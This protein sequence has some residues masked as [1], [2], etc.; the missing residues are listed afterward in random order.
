M[1]KADT[2]GATG[3]YLTS[4]GKQGDAAWG[5]RGRWCLLTGQTE[6]HE[7]DDCDPRPSE[8][9]RISDLLA[10]ARI[11][12]V[13]GESAGAHIFDPKAPPFNFTLEKGQ[14]ATFRY[15]VLLLPRAGSAEEMNRAAD[16]FAATKD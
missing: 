2:S 12:S 5:T 3:V 8:E 4:E 11:W 1:E 16:E 15:R 7:R 6:G 9:S 14:T 13:R 10:R